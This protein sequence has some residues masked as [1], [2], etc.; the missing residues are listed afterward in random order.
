MQSV[1]NTPRLY[2]VN[3]P[4]TPQLPGVLA[5][6]AEP[7]ISTVARPQIR[8][9]SVQ[10]TLSSR[11]TIP[12]A[13]TTENVVAAHFANR[14]TLRSVVAGMLTDALK[15]QYPS[16]DI[17]V[18]T[19]SLA[20]PS[21]AAP[22]QYVLTPLLDLALDHLA[23]GTDLDFTDRHGEPCKWIDTAHFRFLKIIDDN[24]LRSR[25]LDMSTV[26][27]AIRALRPNLKSAFA[28]ALSQYWGQAAF[29]TDPASS[30]WS[31]LSDTLH[32]TLSIAS[33]RQP[34]L[35]ELQRQ[36]LDQVTH[37]PDAAQ[38]QQAAG[39]DAAKVYVIDTTLSKGAVK[40]TLLSADLLIT[41]QVG[42]RTIVLH[43]TAAGKV[44]PYASL[45]AFASAW[46]QQLAQPFDFDQMTWQRRAID[47]NLFDTQ[48]A[49]MLNQQ[50]EN[51]DAVTLPAS[52]SPEDLAQLFAAA[53]ATAPW[54]VGAPVPSTSHARSLASKLPTWLK[55]ASDA[56]RFAYQRL[57]ASLATSVQRN[58]GRT[59]LDGIPDIRLYTQQQLDLALSTKG[60]A[61]KDVE[62]VFKVPVGNMGSGYI[63]RVKMS[64]TDMA[65]ENLSG[66]PK[67]EMDVYVRGQ[68]V[69]DS[70]LPKMLK[71]L[72][73]K[74]DIGKQYPALL[75]RELLSGT[76]AAQQ[77]QAR[78]ID[79]VPI[80]L[81]MQALEL[82]LKGDSGLSALG[83]QYINAVLQ[84]GAGAKRVD[85]Q[86]VTVRPLAFVRKPG[87]TPDVVESMFL[88]EPLD[89]NQ[90]PHILYQPQLQ[91]TLQEFASREALL[92]AIRQ[93]GT[94]QQ[95]VLN[96]LA[97]YRTRA[98]YA[99]GGFNI[100][101]IA[102][103]TLFNEFDPPATPA[104]TTLAVDGYDAASTLRQDL[105]TGDLAKHLFQSNAHSLVNLANGQ[106]TSDTESRWASFKE[107]GLLLLN[108]LLPVL[109]GPGAMAGWL[110][111]LASMENDIEQISE[112]NGK[113]RSAAVVDLL[114]NVALS[115]GHVSPTTPTRTSR[116]IDR[117]EASI[118]LR[119]EA[120]TAPRTVD[121]SIQQ[122]A[123]LENG[124]TVGNDHDAFDFAFSNPRRLTPAQRAH[125]ESFSVTA[126]APSAEPINNGA[127][128]GLF[129]IDNH[130]YAHIDNLWY[131]VAR[132]LDG[133]FIIDPQNKARTG[134]PLKSGPDGRW[135]PDIS[136]KLKGGM[137]RR[138]SIKD[139]IRENAR[140]QKEMIVQYEQSRLE[141]EKTQKALF[142]A[143]RALNRDLDAFTT[144][145]KKLMEQWGLNK[146][147]T[148][149]QYAATYAEQLQSTRN[150]RLKIDQ[151]L[152][153]LERAAQSDIASNER[154]IE[155][156]TPKKIGA[157]VDFAQLKS[158]RSLTYSKSMLGLVLVNKIYARLNNDTTEIS[159]SGEPL[160]DMM[161]RV[162]SGAEKA[163]YDEAIE[164]LKI[165]NQDR[166]GMWRS[167]QALVD[168]LEKWKNDSPSARHSAEKFLS[169][170]KM[171]APSIE[172]KA[173]QLS[174]MANFK[175]LSI[176]GGANAP[177][178]YGV[179]LKERLQS[180]SLRP[181]N[182]TFLDQHEYQGYTFTERKAALT[183]VIDTYE[184]SLNDVETLHELH[185]E[186]FRDE[187]RP[188]FIQRVTEV[189]D[190]A[191]T[192]LADA[193]REEQDLS[194]V[195]PKRADKPEKDSKR[196]VFT[197]RDKQTLI[198]TLR[199]PTEGQNN[200][201]DVLDP[202]TGQPIA[203]YNEHPAQREWVKQVAYKPPVAKPPRPSQPLNTYKNEVR[204]I[205]EDSVDNERT[206]AFQKR[207]LNDPTRRDGL[208]P[209]D[210][211]DMCENLANRLKATAQQ[212]ETEHGNKPG[213]KELVAQWRAK[214]DELLQEGRQHT[215]D[216]YKV[217]TPRQ[218]NVDFLW[219]HGFVDINL[220]KRAIP[221]GSGDVF[222]EYAV[223]E[224]GSHEVLWYAHFHYPDAATPRNAY[225]A[226]HLKIPS[227][228]YE[229]QKTMIAKAGND[230]KE[231][232]KIV[233]ARITPPLDEK[234][235]LKL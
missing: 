195:L 45:E 153:E 151:G 98:V 176:I 123:P 48:A 137:P 89:A 27:L 234:L 22:L 183:T 6:P 110:M 179:F 60:Y 42:E 160:S 47:G 2:T 23:S 226:A 76:E 1:R 104:P 209:L 103:Y 50:L 84:P 29:R 206:I 24:G 144:A 13:S 185:P 31:W 12:P 204:K 4:T 205:I 202:K 111:Q 69:V 127:S 59:F 167:Q 157:I 100:P 37:Y 57:T 181:V 150:L 96:W 213:T 9:S 43:A 55:Q 188:L 198:G 219:T 108:T 107:V 158:M 10:P 228:R 128:K 162:G 17:N 72:I 187:Y 223:R 28:Q 208:T 34:D 73:S 165:I 116:F 193:L 203:T 224:K 136:P 101:H 126:P 211:N 166:E 36:T 62:V 142:A 71:D 169:E 230:K 63:E 49:I 139:M 124:L 217:Q 215:A 191:R 122:V 178:N 41:R 70:S 220:V 152:P 207:K 129:S 155:L 201:I 51:L 99:N 113:D 39:D 90:G 143:V 196:R 147:D 52:S 189:L 212:V 14:P 86:E 67:G 74:V 194:P 115:L 44:T 182:Q 54:F 130:L 53:T 66:L 163:T 83:Y 172:A 91:P 232:E 106:S 25:L 65:L 117:P 210:W 33:L 81:A 77:R 118:P 32:T 171:V 200:V 146:G 114:V 75:E 218:E 173:S 95:N 149:S 121:A 170:R 175:E 102:R 8:T 225:T 64:L 16:L 112:P 61:A 164:N 18:A 184:Q 168:Q 109:R 78:F 161:S 5:P 80:Q 119:R 133:T 92:E 26:E 180:T 199:A 154:T 148:A 131:R 134:P 97:D 197:T 145:R 40:A 88:I 174:I 30:H 56:E 19:T 227:Q 93:P 132:D 222:T 38:R 21:Q 15:T 85:G 159:L 68:Q 177:S 214:S 156:I 125:I 186:V 141:G 87:A 192:D 11:F 3:L 58:A 231:V 46:S 138:K 105:L 79:Q 94:L 221:S 229:T 135:Y 140:A 20:V 82:K 120:T 35:D 233:R 7:A 235:F 216:G 190:E